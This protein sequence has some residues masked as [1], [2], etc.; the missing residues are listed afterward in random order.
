MY[1][2]DSLSNFM[3]WSFLVKVTMFILSSIS[4]IL[5]TYKG[6]SIK[7][8]PP[9]SLL[10]IFMFRMFRCVSELLSSKICCVPSKFSIKNWIKFTPPLNKLKMTSPKL[11]TIT[12]FKLLLLLI[13]LIFEFI[14]F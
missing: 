5:V 6:D 3:Y 1:Q 11:K 10:R 4:P 13:R 8:L 2:T 7:L 14:L 12:F 9:F